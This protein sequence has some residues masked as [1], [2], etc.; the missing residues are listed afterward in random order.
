MEEKG[1]KP[2]CSLTPPQQRSSDPTTYRCVPREADSPATL[3]SMTERHLHSDIIGIDGLP[4]CECMEDGPSLLLPVPGRAATR[5]N[6][7]LTH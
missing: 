4:M 6:A 2:Q 5:G 3:M 7:D 1:A